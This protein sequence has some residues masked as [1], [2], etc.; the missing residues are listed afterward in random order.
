MQGGVFASARCVRLVSVRCS[1]KERLVKPWMVL[2]DAQHPRSL[3][4]NI[5]G[6]RKWEAGHRSARE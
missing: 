2:V 3:P 4:S 6:R 5:V 1:E